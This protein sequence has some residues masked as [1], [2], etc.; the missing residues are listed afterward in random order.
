MYAVACTYICVPVLV[1]FCVYMYVC[2][3]VHVDPRE[4]TTLGAIP[5]VYLPPLK[6][7]IMDVCL[8]VCHRLCA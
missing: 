2:V 4:Q 8:Y 6:I 7:F 1:F 3:Y 5:Q